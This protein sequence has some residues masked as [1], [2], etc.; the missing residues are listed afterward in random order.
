MRKDLKNQ[1][2]HYTGRVVNN[3]KGVF[4]NYKKSGLKFTGSKLPL[5][6]S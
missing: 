5:Q 4:Y 1:G 3:E 2:R 6:R